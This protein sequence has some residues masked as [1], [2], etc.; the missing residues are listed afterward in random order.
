MSGARTAVVVGSGPNGLAG[1]ITLARAGLDVTVLE[2]ADSVGGGMRSAPLTFPGF[3]HDVCSAAHP[4]AMASP[5]MRSIDWA[6]HG[7]EFL[8]PGL[9]FG[10]PLDGG[11]AA[12][13]HRSVEETADGLGPD[14]AV[15]RRLLTP[16]VRDAL[17]LA[18]AMLGSGFRPPVPHLA[19]IARFGARSVLPTALLA[20]TFR[21]DLAPALLA[22]AAAHSTLPLTALPTTP[23]GLLLVLLAHAVGWPVVRG[24]T[25]QMADALV[26]EL[27]ALGGRL[28]TGSWVRSAA[29]L[30]S[31]DIVLL[32]VSPR[33]L[34]SIYGEALAPR[35]AR[36][37]ERFRYGPGVCKV[38]FAL[39]GPVPWTAPGLARAGTVHVGGTWQDIAES[40]QQPTRGRHAE[41]PYVLAVQPGVVDPTRAPAGRATLW[42]YCH[43]PNGST[44]DM[45]DRITAQVERFAPGFAA[46]VLDRTVCTAGAEEAHDPNWVGGD[47]S[48]G[49]MTVRQTLARPAARWDLY[50]VPLAGRAGAAAAS[51]G[52]WLCS[53]ATPPGPGVHGMSGHVAAVRA[54]AAAGVPTPTGAARAGTSATD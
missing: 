52:T 40:E 43:V 15:Y 5:F 54:L 4:L 44:V 3:T 51:A 48:T 19:A 11:R 16:L 39:S 27:T 21:G 10:Q 41:R 6:R 28:H 34:L 2:G 35:Y 13:A 53:S 33:A 36:A 32:D 26:A 38:D 50:R 9:P 24:G 20:R 25:Q 45:G 29:D 37:V 1:A 14:G 17:P 46:T 49:A 31:A 7:V 42:T 47:I 23:T 8:Q 22:G 30:P 12:L 18:D